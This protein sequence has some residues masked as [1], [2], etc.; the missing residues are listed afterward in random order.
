[1]S[2]G[3]EFDEGLVEGRSAIGVLEG[4]CREGVDGGGAD[5]VVGVVQTATERVGRRACGD[6]G[7]ERDGGGGHACVVPGRRGVCGRALAPRDGEKREDLEFKVGGQ[8][9]IACETHAGQTL[10][11]GA[12]SERTLEAERRRGTVAGGQPAQVHSSRDGGQIITIEPADKLFGDALH[13][14]IR[15]ILE[16][17][18]GTKNGLGVRRVRGR[19]G[20]GVEERRSGDIG[21]GVE[22][23][24][25]RQIRGE[26]GG[27]QHRGVASAGVGVQEHRLQGPNKGGIREG[28]CAEPSRE[29][30]GA[31][32]G[33][34]ADRGLSRQRSREGGAQRTGPERGGTLRV[35]QQVCAGEQCICWKW[36][37]AEGEPLC[38]GG[39][40]RIKGEQ[41]QSGDIQQRVLISSQNRAEAENRRMVG[42]GKDGAERSGKRGQT[43]GRREEH[44]HREQSLAPTVGIEPLGGDRERV[45][46]F[47][48]KGPR[49]KGGGP[50]G[51][52]DQ[53][54]S[55]RSGNGRFVGEQGSEDGRNIGIVGMGKPLGDGGSLRGG[56]SGKTETGGERPALPRRGGKGGLV[57]RRQSRV[58]SSRDA[59]GQIGGRRAGE[60]K[61]RPDQG[62]APIGRAVSQRE[63]HGPCL[64]VW[65][66]P[67]DR[68]PE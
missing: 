3:L 39:A 24:V 49:T 50:R 26:T 34:S 15:R 56:R 31:Q 35:K 57:W 44:E 21:V 18:R 7:Q 27:G 64:G 13:A 30:T 1:M 38:R 55:G 2:I 65:I 20:R 23:E 60:V 28:G 45:G 9:K 36:T 68:G 22:G 54:L 53:R 59:Q 66:A 48:A 51:E 17:T 8:I 11:E 12:L 63:R 33:K 10:S 58:R 4:V 6:A 40:E 41:R 14:G 37:G 43:A 19:A 32:R 62:R 46:E 52:H 47:A 16:P 5:A 67:G 42:I 25:E 29:G 61:E